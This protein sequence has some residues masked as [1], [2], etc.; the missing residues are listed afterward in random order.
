MWETPQNSGI[1]EDDI[2]KFHSE[3]PINIRRQRTNSVAGVRGIAWRERCGPVRP[4][5]EGSKGQKTEYC[6]Q[7]KYVL[8]STVPK[9][10]RQITGNSVN[11]FL[12]FIISVRGGR[13][14]YPPGAPEKSSCVAT[15]GFYISDINTLVVKT[16]TITTTL[17]EESSDIQNLTAMFAHHFDGYDSRIYWRHFVI[18]SGFL[19]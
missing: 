17:I 10:V 15:R 11:D 1:Q 5:P 18:C 14:D 2:R 6:Q 9:P 19:S 3:D 16:D 13:C 12:K 7:E 4:S 8:C